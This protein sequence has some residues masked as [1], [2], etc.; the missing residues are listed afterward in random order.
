MSDATAGLIGAGMFA[1]TAVKGLPQ[2]VR[3][4]RTRSVRGLSLTAFYGDTLV[5]LTKVVYHVRRGYAISAWAE[6]LV[7]L[8]FNMFCTILCHFFGEAGVLRRFLRKDEDVDLTASQRLFLGVSDFGVLSSIA[9]ILFRVFPEPMLPFLCVGLS[10]LICFTYAAQITV[11]YRTKSTGELAVLTVFL[12]WL[13]STIRVFTTWL[14]LAGDPVVLINHAL[15]TIGCTVLLIQIYWYN[16]GGGY[17]KR[18]LRRKAN[19]DKK[20]ALALWRGLGGFR[21]EVATQQPLSE[22][23]LRNAFRTIDKND[24]GKISREELQAAVEA[25]SLS[26]KTSFFA[27]DSKAQSQSVKSMYKA[28]NRDG[29]GCISFEEFC[30]F[31]RGL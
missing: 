28:V 29:D 6:L 19:M 12:R 31:I 18:L 25:A 13:A 2:I 8:S 21:N 23:E 7:L 14:Q 20:A 22:K 5:F 9:Y 4:I 1:M 26:D 10:P 17:F 30:Q 27:M 3:I 11:N 15:G 24:S 16:A